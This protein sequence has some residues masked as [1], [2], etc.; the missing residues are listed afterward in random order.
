MRLA[1]IGLFVQVLFYIAS[2]VNHFWHSPF[3]LRIMPDHY[4]HPN[5]WVQGSGVA[6]I[7][8]GIGLA[9]PVSRRWA[10]FGLVLLLIVFLDVHLFMLSHS[11]RFPEIPRWMLWARLPLQG[12]LIA[13]ALYYARIR[14]KSLPTGN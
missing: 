3:Y 1:S 11:Q 13:W 7:L 4:A 10:S 6:E 9:I 8:G 12:F 14:H 5:F 2:G